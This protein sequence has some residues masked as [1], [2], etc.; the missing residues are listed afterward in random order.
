MPDRVVTPSLDLYSTHNKTLPNGDVEVI[1]TGY[2]DNGSFYRNGGKMVLSK[3]QYEHFRSLANPVL[4]MI[5]NQNTV[6]RNRK[7]ERGTAFSIGEN[8][9]LTN[10]HVL[11]H[12]KKIT[13]CNGF[14]LKDH[15]NETFRC[16]KVHYCNPT[17]DVCLIEMQTK[18]K[19][20]CVF[21]DKPAYE[22]SLAQGPS[23]KLKSGVALN[24]EERESIITTAIG[25]SGGYGIQLSQGRGVT[26]RGG[27]LC[28]YAPITF[29]N[30]GGP[31]LNE[32]GLVIGV[33]Y[34]QSE[35]TKGTDINDVYNV[36]TLSDV[37]IS[38]IRENLV[39]DPETLEKFNQAVV[40]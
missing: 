27:A 3:A 5:P 12:D 40:E 19:K 28:F 32:E 25:N 6:D 37:V 7:T 21:C 4:E 36:S 8:L 31:L 16:K 14:Q 10:H 17:H 33:V 30:S 38:L 18:K 39:D 24:Y 15:R 26:Y 20:D 9:V 1:V 29:G 13:T 22:V 11:D 35:K 2:R 23:L 34:A